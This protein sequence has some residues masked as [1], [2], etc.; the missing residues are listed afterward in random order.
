M[1]KKFIYAII[2]LV[3]LSLVLIVFSGKKNSNTDN[4]SQTIEKNVVQSPLVA[5]TTPPNT[6]QDIVT[7]DVK[8][9]FVTG[10]NY[11]FVPPQIVVKKGDTVKINFKDGGGFHDLKIDEF[12]VATKKLKNGESDTVTF[13]ADKAGSFEYYCSIGN[14]RAMG[15]KGV[16]IV[17]E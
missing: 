4:S 10:N 17:K 7:K 1:N 8:E 14:H 15:M 16:L 2:A 5:S 13:I 12:G 11:T 3:I 6:K 9:F